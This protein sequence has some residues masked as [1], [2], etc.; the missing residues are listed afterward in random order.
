[1]T[2][3]EKLEA[4][5]HILGLCRD[6]NW[7]TEQIGALIAPDPSESQEAAVVAEIGPAPSPEPPAE[8]G[9]DQ[10]PEAA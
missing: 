10:P 8:E 7:T 4:I 3:E 2:A 9:E 6:P 1:M 5:R